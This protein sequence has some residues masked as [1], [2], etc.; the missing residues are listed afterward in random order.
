MLDHVDRSEAQ[1]KRACVLEVIHEASL[2][3]G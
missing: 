1:G 2:E 3:H